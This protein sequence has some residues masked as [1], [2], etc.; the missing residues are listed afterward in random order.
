MKL[1]VIGYWHGYPGRE[2]A[3][4]GYLLEQGETKLLLDC[5]SGVLSHVQAYCPLEELDGIVLSHYHQDHMAD[6]GVFH[7][8]R[9]LQAGQGRIKKQATIYGHRDDPET[10][11]TLSYKHVVRSETYDG[12]NPKVIGPFQFSFF[13]TKHP[14]P[15][16]AMRIEV[17][18][19][20]LVYT[21]DTSYFAE[22]ANFAEGCDLLIAECSAYGGTDLSD[23][24]HM[25][26]FD[27]GILAERTNARQLLLTHLPHHGQ[28]EQLVAEV[29]TKY[30]G[31]I[32]LANTGWVKEW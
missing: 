26:S 17:E 7:Y 21:A 12:L 30:Q 15:C 13:K 28:H 14:V 20:S 23:Y 3:T 18:G 22:L 16:Y 5:G 6:I 32:F 8:A 9:L 2:G 19:Q 11:S 24:G 27:V 25:N 4:S 31:E 29:K 10:F 1:T